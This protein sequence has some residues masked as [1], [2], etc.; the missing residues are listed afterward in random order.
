M[1]TSV[2]LGVVAL[3]AFASNASAADLPVKTRPLVA[4]PIPWTWTG[5]YIGGHIGGAWGQSTFREPSGSLIC[6]STDCVN[7]TGM[8]DADGPVSGFLG[9]GQ[10]GFNLQMG[11][12]WV[13]GIEADVSGTDLKGGFPCY[14]GIA[15]I[16]SE[17]STDSCTAKSSVMGTIVGRL[18]PTVGNAW[19]YLLGGG[20]WIRNRYTDDYFFPD[21]YG[22]FVVGYSAS[23]TR[24]GWTVG[25]GIEYAIDANWSAKVQYNYMDFGTHQLTFNAPADAF[26]CPCTY[27]ENIEQR[28]HAVKV[29]INYRFG[30]WG[31]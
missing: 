1:R 6:G 15:Q 18:G 20:A 19:V 24:W 11:P 30:W 9:G 21:R 12:K 31:Y 13:W 14:V 2:L 7:T 23:E 17:P 22:N 5:F 27:V 25:G 4:A 10:I 26:D 29:G 28:I 16:K 3:A 8:V